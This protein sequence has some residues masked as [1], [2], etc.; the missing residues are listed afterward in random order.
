MFNIIHTIDKRTRI[1]ASLSDP[2][3]TSN[4]LNVTESDLIRVQVDIMDQ[5]IS[6]CCHSFLQKN[7]SGLTTT[8]TTSNSSQK[9]STQMNG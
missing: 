4:G 8:R 5:W 6:A 2:I 3:L 9:F 7:Y 1:S